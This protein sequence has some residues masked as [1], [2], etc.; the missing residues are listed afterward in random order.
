MAKAIRI[1]RPLDVK[2]EI[3]KNSRELEALRSLLRISER[4]YGIS[5]IREAQQCDK[6]C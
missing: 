3:A 2:K 1:P 5:A 6:R 4:F